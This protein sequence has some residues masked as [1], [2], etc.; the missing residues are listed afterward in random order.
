MKFKVKDKYYGYGKELEIIETKR[1]LGHEYF[2]M[3]GTCGR[4]CGGQE[5]IDKIKK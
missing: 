4:V 5:F 2:V 3:I 1:L